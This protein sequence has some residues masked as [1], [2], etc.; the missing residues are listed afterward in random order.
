MFGS[1]N[2]PLP[3]GK[4]NILNGSAA[5][6]VP[7]I[8][9][10]TAVTMKAVEERNDYQIWALEYGVK[11]YKIRHV[12]SDNYLSYTPWAVP[13]R[14]LGATN[15]VTASAKSP[16]EWK[17]VQNSAGTATRSFQLVVI[18][19]AVR[20]HHWVLICCGM[21]ESVRFLDPTFNQLMNVISTGTAA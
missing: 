2:G 19:P 15:N 14:I 10:H 12:A 7:I 5:L 18:G 11:G 4:Y 20:A 1:F 6:W 3:E 8:L 13:S 17:L 16:V 21:E 9:N